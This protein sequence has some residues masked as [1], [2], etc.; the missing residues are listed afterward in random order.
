[1]SDSEHT[2][3]PAV[4]GDVLTTASTINVRFTEHEARSLRRGSVFEVTADVLEYSKNRYGES[5]FD[6]LSPEAQCR[7][8]GMVKFLRGDQSAEVTWWNG[9]ETERDRFRQEELHKIET[10]R[11]PVSKF[12]AKQ[13]LMELVGK[14]NGVHSEFIPGNVDANGRRTS[15]W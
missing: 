10:L 7:R 12:E 2:P 6:D 3:A 13:Q 9:S 15:K 4:V 5:V 11:D 8:W 1:M 14:K